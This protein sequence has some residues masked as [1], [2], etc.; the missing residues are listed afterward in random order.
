MKIDCI[1]KVELPFMLNIP[2]G[3][4][5]VGGAAIPYLLHVDQGQVAAHLEDGRF[6][7]GSETII[8]QEFGDQIKVTHWQPLRTLVSHTSSIDLAETDL[9]LLNEDK[10]HEAM[11]RKI[12][13]ENP[14]EFAGKTEDLKSEATLRLSAMEKDSRA[15]FLRM[16]SV[17]EY[18]RRLANADL[19]LA[20]LNRLIRLY[21]AQF[22]DFFVEEVTL[23]QLASNTPLKGVVMLVNCDGSFL[24]NYGHV[25]KLPPI[26]FRPWQ[27]HPESKLQEF[28]AH[29]EAGQLPDAIDLMAVRS[30]NCL[31]K[32]AYR[33]AIAEA[34]A[35]MDL[36]LSSKIR[37][38]LRAR[39]RSDSD[40]N[41]LLRK[42][43]NQRFEERAKTILNDATGQ[44]VPALNNTLWSDVSAHRTVIRQGVTHSNAEP[45]KDDAEKVVNDFLR[46]AQLIRTIS[47][48]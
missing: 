5:P 41:D 28:K 45:E 19:F 24:H 11:Q 29:L 12:I 40:I 2:S 1:E 20:N 33:S 43:Q 3:I 17:R 38:G 44:T 25:G 4:Y 22:N 23:H 32:G 26:M 21:M 15:A 35:A 9:P 36:S 16:E 6:A 18:S 27:N 10:L 46:L 14:T 48:R 37:E 8:K 30:R 42:P 13:G 47:V 39:G 31:E 34:S 7:I